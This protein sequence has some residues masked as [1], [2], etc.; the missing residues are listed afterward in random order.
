MQTRSTFNCRRVSNCLCQL[1][2][3]FNLLVLR[4]NYKLCVVLADG[5]RVSEHESICTS[6]TLFTAVHTDCSTVAGLYC[7]VGAAVDGSAAM[8]VY[9]SMAADTHLKA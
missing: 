2:Y 3:C 9:G 1:N 5:E 8:Q 7:T 6:S 4:C